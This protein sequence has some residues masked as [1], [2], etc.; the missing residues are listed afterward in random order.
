MKTSIIPVL[1]FLLLISGCNKTPAPVEPVTGQEF[2][3]KY[4]ETVKL[5]GTSLIL[6]FLYV[7]EDSRCPIDAVCKWSGNAKVKLLING[8]EAALNTHVLPKDTVI[9][10]YKIKLIDVAPYPQVAKEINQQDY[11]IKLLIE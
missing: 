5:K 6:K 8:T 11:I 7:T 10:D 9:A 4:G 3:I 1:A 2:E